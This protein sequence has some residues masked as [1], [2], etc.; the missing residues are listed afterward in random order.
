MSKKENYFSVGHKRKQQHK[1]CRRDNRE[2]SYKY[3]YVLLKKTPYLSILVLNSFVI[4]GR[5]P[6]NKINLFCTRQI[7]Q[8]YFYHQT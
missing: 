7:H 1:R 8:T 2:R 5:S 3:K 6:K 4:Y